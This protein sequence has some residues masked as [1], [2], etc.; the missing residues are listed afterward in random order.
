MDN[1][2]SPFMVTYIS[3]F[4]KFAKGTKAAAARRQFEVVNEQPKQPAIMRI[5][6]LSAMA[7]KPKPA[8]ARLT[9]VKPEVPSESASQKP[10][11]TKT[12]RKLVPSTG[13]PII[14]PKSSTPVINKE[15]PQT[16]TPPPFDRKPPRRAMSMHAKALVPVQPRRSAAAVK[17]PTSSP[18]TDGPAEKK[19]PMRPI[20]PVPFRV[21][22]KVIKSAPSQVK[23][24]AP[25][26]PPPLKKFVK[27]TG[28]NEGKRSKVTAQPVAAS[29]VADAKMAEVEAGSDAAE[30]EHPADEQLVVSRPSITIGLPSP[31]IV[32]CKQKIQM[33]DELKDIQP[34]DKFDEA[35][36]KECSLVCQR[37]QYPRV[38]IDEALEARQ[39]PRDPIAGG[40][41]RQRAQGEPLSGDLTAQGRPRQR[42]QGI[43]TKAARAGTQRKPHT[44]CGRCLQGMP[45]L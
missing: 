11:E 14:K 41:H 34:T 40:H 1:P 8:P 22:T 13:P 7:S 4:N 35:V 3:S 43:C 23:R 32:M 33:V 26:P 24:A 25:P 37:Y 5:A 17:L 45:S 27:K 20:K 18:R 30:E 44:E 2:R 36:R 29:T 21:A 16:M 10:A 12:I 31:E 42:K 38:S 19:T 28:H 6:Q 39:R 9:K 15:V